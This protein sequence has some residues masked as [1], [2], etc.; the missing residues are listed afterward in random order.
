MVDFQRHPAKNNLANQNYQNDKAN[1]IQTPFHSK[2]NNWTFFG[3]IR[4]L[5]RKHKATL[6]KV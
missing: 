5:S 6:K 1:S 2:Q 4:D 3:V